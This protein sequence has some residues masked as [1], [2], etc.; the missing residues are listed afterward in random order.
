[1]LSS[2]PYLLRRRMYE[3]GLPEKY[4]P[5]NYGSK[6]YTAPFAKLPGGFST[7]S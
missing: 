3:E 7:F 5:T 6:I 4:I 2:N 1:M